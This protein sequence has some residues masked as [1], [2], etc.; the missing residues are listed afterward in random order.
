M[1]VAI[2]Y[3][4][5]H[6]NN[7]TLA[8]LLGDLLME[9]GHHVDLFDMEQARPTD[10]P[11]A[12]L[13]VFGSP[14]HLSRVPGKAKKFL[15]DINPT[16]GSRYAI[17]ATFWRSEDKENENLG[18]LPK[19][20]KLISDKGMS[21]V[22]EQAFFVRAVKGPLEEGYREKMIDFAGRILTG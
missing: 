16:K 13:Y 14:T 19:L 6:G 5:T 20:E 3:L 7:R 18:T 12:E 17:M 15:K 22:G 10:L 8:E 4:T 1:R 2:A 21:K 9:R 11:E